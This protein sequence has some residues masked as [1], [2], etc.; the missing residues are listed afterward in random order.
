[1]VTFLGVSHHVRDPGGGASQTHDFDLV[2]PDGT[3]IAVEV[4]RFNVQEQVQSWTEI[5]K[6]SW[7]FP[8]LQARW[9]VTFVSGR[10]V[11]AAHRDLPL[12]LEGFERR[13]VMRLDIRD[14]LSPHH[15]RDPEDP[16][17][18]EATAPVDRSDA[19][20]LWSLGVLRICNIG[21]GD[22]GIGEILMNEPPAI[23][24]SSADVAIQVVT[25]VAWLPDNL[26]K[27]RGSG[28]HRATSLHLGG[29]LSGPR[30]GGDQW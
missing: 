6:R 17:G 13:G 11:K 18:E 9:L 28:R 2:L 15:S 26:A 30:R 3:S 12:L 1:M 24:N 23:G 27:L 14:L 29:R 22:D 20:A 7:R 21:P 4:T 25:D 19:E 5:Q 16:E 8:N 10:S